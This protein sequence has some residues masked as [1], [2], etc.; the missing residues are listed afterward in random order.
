[1]IGP[2]NEAG[3]TAI[4]TADRDAQSLKRLLS[5]DLR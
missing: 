4:V 3:L 5:L 1:M 2:E